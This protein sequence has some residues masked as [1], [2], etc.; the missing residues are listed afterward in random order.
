MTVIV[1]TGELKFESF[2]IA[3]SADTGWL[4]FYFFGFLP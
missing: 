3:F 2:G 4:I 1:V